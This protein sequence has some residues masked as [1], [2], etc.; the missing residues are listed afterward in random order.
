M[1]SDNA[2]YAVTY[3]SISSD[4]NGPSWGIPL[5]NAGEFPKMDPY[6]EVAQQ[7]QAHTLSHAYVPYLM[8]LDEHVP[9]YVS[10]PENPEYHA[11][12]DDDIQVEDQPH[13]DDAS[14]TA[15]SPGYI[16][17][18]DLMDEDDDED[19]EEDLEEDPS[20]EHE[21]EDDN[22]DPNKENEPEDEDTKEPSEDSDETGPFKEDET[23]VTP[24][25]P[26]HRGARISVR[27][28]KPMATST[29]ALIDAFADGSSPLPLPP[30]SPAYDQAQLGHR[31][32][33]IYMRGDIPEED[34]PPRRRFVFTAPPP[35]CD[36]AESS[37]AAARAPRGQYDFVDTVEAGQ[38]LIRSPDH[39]TQTIARAADRAEDVGY[40]R[41]LQASE[42]RMMTSIEDTDRKD[43]RL[44]IEVVRGQRTAY[45]TK[46]QE[47]QSAE[48]LAVTQM[49]RIHALEAR[50]QT[51]T[52]HAC[53]KTRTNDAMTPESIQAMIDRAIQR[54]YTYTQDDASQS[55]SGG[56]RRPVQPARVCFYTDFMKCQPLNFKGTEGVVGLSQ[57]L[58]KKESVFHISGCA[59]NNQVKF[60]TCTLLGAAWKQILKKKTKPKPKTTKPNTKW[61]R[62]RKTKSFEAKSQKS[63][64][65]SSKVN[66][67]NGKVNPDKA[68][69][70]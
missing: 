9:V 49:M 68:E 36:V 64:P 55:S 58:E 5:M 22:E 67:G 12:S 26:R 27:P 32:T 53:N 47:R 6:E 59:I 62:S 43:I 10:E 39:D 44:E 20:E 69:A 46:L 21:P 57:W 24:P 51:D 4:S 33:M 65:R 34:M 40:A 3:T 38:V 14:P 48:D 54:N 1:S 23:A 52:N 2:H 8:E 61:K 11:P 66:P 7:G 28:Q 13:A 17:D 31:T 42:R 18:S 70:E 25:P 37:A 50:A 29:Q 19:P 63:K 56:P 35:G 16:A 60:A 30:T 45:E 15:E 41:A